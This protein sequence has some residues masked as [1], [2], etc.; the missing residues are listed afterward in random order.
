MSWLAL[1]HSAPSS[2]PD[3]E[4][5]IPSRDD[6]TVGLAFL[7]LL[8]LAIAVLLPAATMTLAARRGWLRQPTST[9]AILILALLPLAFTASG[10]LPGRALTPTSTL[11]G[12]TPWSDYE[13]MAKIAATSE[14]PNPI[15]LDPLTTMIPWS[16]AA[17]DGWLFNP[18][19]GGGAAL[20]GNGQSAV[21]FPTEMLSR[22]LPPFRA[23]TWS[24]AAR[25]LLAVWG[26]FLLAR[27]FG[28]SE[29]GAL[30]AAATFVGSGFLQMGRLH[31]LS[32]VAAMAPWVVLA[33][34]VLVRRPGPRPA[35]GL[36]VAGAVSFFGGHPETLLHVLVFTAL[37][38][39]PL[40]L[41]AARERGLLPRQLLW[42]TVAAGLSF[43]LAAPVLLPFVDN[44]RFAEEWQSNRNERRRAIEILLPDS[45]DRLATAVALLAHGDP[46]EGSWNGPENLIEVGGGAVGSV[47]L[48]LAAL[49][50]ASPNP[51]RRRLALLLLAI[52]LLG[53]LVGSHVPWVSKPFKY[54]PL[55][56]DSLL[57]R[58]SLWWVLGVALLAAMGVD[59]V[60]RSPRSRWLAWL[61]AGGLAVLLAVVMI[62]APKSERPWIFILELLPLLGAAVAVGMA[63]KAAGQPPGDGRAR[64]VAFALAVVVAALLFPRSV[65][66]A[67]WI[68]LASALSFY[69]E[70]P[71][72][73]HVAERLRTAEPVGYRVAG[74]DAALVPHSAAFFGF[75]DV[76][77]YDPMG[78]APYHRFLATL[79]EVPRAGWVRILNSARPA[80]A[81]LGV[82]WIFHHQIMGPK[83][84]VE[85]IYAG[86]DAVIYEVPGVLP[87]LFVPRELAVEPD[88]DKAVVAA[89]KITDFAQLAVVERGP[90][91]SAPA[92]PAFPNPAAKV[93]SLVVERGRIRATV[94]TTEPAVVV[95]SQPA[96]P[97]WR[98]RLDGTPA[99]ERLLRTNG[100]FLG[101]EIFPG[102]HDLELCYA[103][104]SWVWGL[105]LGAVG[106][107]VAA[108]LLRS[109]KL[110]GLPR[111]S[112]ESRRYLATRRLV[113]GE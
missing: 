8:Y 25:L 102:R 17:R 109:G 13:L 53:L 72:T 78:F 107:A 35:V 87:R 66:L 28:V 18:T 7:V 81:F 97:G 44:L 70:T 1:L 5:S 42:G 6:D 89:R 52:G 108:G 49:A 69:P 92:A 56:R 110:R 99:P 63:K 33:A 58:L 83:P 104:A 64:R 37:L 2:K 75:E 94:E 12:V 59:R 79:G 112:R 61:A 85:I 103:P 4:T 22:L 95:S 74:F 3:R 9:K 96:I 71:A 10:F 54:V 106:L 34:I 40:G 47:A 62:W 84:G 88:V 76:R 26:M 98:L 50:F 113:A 21:L 20:L 14:P 101:V 91:G 16:R 90:R 80:L 43:L 86:A 27:V 45:L 82:R 41:K 68:P 19:Q 67:R 65:L 105:T 111:P 32:M 100:A 39:I 30:V 46:R 93:F 60:T 11:A 29:L 55:L 48:L 73:R 51:E 38:V 77:A 31:P 24:Q 23:V 36:A 15:L 57:K